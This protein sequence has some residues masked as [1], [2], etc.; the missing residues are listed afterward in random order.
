MQL[1]AAGLDLSPLPGL[2]RLAAAAMMAYYQ[3]DAGVRLKADRS[4]LTLADEASNAVLIR[5][6]AAAYP[7]VPVVSEESDNAPYAA[8]RDAPHVFIVDPLDGTREFLAANGEFTVNI[9]LVAAGRAVFGLLY[10]PCP[11]AMYFGGPGLG[12]WRQDGGQAA[13]AISTVKP[14]P[15]EHPVALVSRS[16][17]D[18]GVEALLAPFA[19]YRTMALGAALKFTAVAEGAAHVYPRARALHEWDMAAGQ[20]IV[21]GAGGSMAGLDGRPIVYNTEN[22][23]AGPFLA[24]A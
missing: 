10:A 2:A 18:P 13:R 16:H 23:M 14:R 7:G 5:E 20:A 22:L 6:L 17:P 21:E 12:A 19:P 8:R 9:A 15:G 24:L 1:R 3:K 11:D 4:P